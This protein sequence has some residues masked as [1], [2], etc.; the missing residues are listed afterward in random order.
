MLFAQ[1]ILTFVPQIYLWHPS[2]IIK[3]RNQY[4]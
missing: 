1:V 2:F 3:Y 4:V